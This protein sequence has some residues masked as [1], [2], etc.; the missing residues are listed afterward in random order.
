MSTGATISLDSTLRRCKV[1]SSWANTLKSVHSIGSGSEKLCP[2]WSGF[3]TV[4]RPI[5]PD[6]FNTKSAGCNSALDRLH[7]E[8]EISRPQ[9]IPHPNL[10][11]T[12][13][14]G[15]WLYN[16]MDNSTTTQVVGLN[17]PQM[18]S[19][20]KQGGMCGYNNYLQ[21]QVQFDH[22]EQPCNL[23]T[24]YRQLGTYY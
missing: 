9:Y 16:D 19:Y 2:V 10:S 18:T 23:T 5:C 12:G 8:N 17:E 15:D 22:N 1:D 7:V 14:T 13:V 24:P 21:S 20:V 6:S 4:G 3:D 11:M